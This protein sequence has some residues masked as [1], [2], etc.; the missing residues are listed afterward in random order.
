V[1]DYG[2]D[3]C[4][5]SLE[6]GGEPCIADGEPCN[7]LGSDESY[8]TLG[9]DPNGDNVD[10]FGDDWHEIN[11]PDSTEGNKQWD[12]GEPFHDWGSDMVPGIPTFGVEADQYEGNGELNWID[13]NDDGD[14]DDGEGEQWFDTG[15]DGKYNA[16][17]VENYSTNNRTEGNFEFNTGERFSPSPQSKNL[18]P[19][20]N[21]KFPS[22]RLLVE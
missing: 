8:S 22:V 20:L 6:S 13:I 10:P 3:W 15:S 12:P 19:V 14:W 16:D 9:P 18:S 21:S 11:N 4:P 17:E 7:C 2:T 1:F 5:D